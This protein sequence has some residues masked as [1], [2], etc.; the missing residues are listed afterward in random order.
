MPGTGFPNSLAKMKVHMLK[1]YAEVM[2]NRIR[3]SRFSDRTPSFVR[4]PK[5]GDTGF[6][7]E[8]YTSPTPAYEV[9][10]C[11]SNGETIWLEPM[12]PDEIDAIPDN[13]PGK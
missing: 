2:V 4:H 8:I 5:V 6:I 9:E 7:V 10:C 13:E 11:Q 12:Y 1:Q 3:D